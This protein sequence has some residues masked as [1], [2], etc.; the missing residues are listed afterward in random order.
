MK[1]QVL[2]IT[3]AAGIALALLAAPA[4]AGFGLLDFFKAPRIFDAEI[5]APDDDSGAIILTGLFCDD[6]S[7]YQGTPTGFQKL[8]FMES[9]TPDVLRAELARYEPGITSKFGVVC[10]YH[11]PRVEAIDVTIPPVQPEREVLEEDQ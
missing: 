11:F 3:S 6:P 7:V 5:V 9:P 4:R 8:L 1:R 10:G 2:V